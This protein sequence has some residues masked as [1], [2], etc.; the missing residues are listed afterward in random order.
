MKWSNLEEV[1]NYA[2]FGCLLYWVFENHLY[3]YYYYWSKNQKRESPFFCI[4]YIAGLYLQLIKGFQML[5]YSKAK[6]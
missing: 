6:F 1:K 2:F 5:C 4:I 3:F